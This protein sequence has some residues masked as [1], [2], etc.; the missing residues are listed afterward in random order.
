M[1]YSRNVSI[2]ALQELVKNFQL[3]PPSPRYGYSFASWAGGRILLPPCGVRSAEYPSGVCSAE[4]PAGRGLVTAL[5][6]EL[7]VAFVS[8]VQRVPG[9]CPVQLC[10]LLQRSIHDS[11]AHTAARGWLQRARPSADS[12]SPSR[13][14]YAF[15][16]RE[17]CT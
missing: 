7:S 8:A 17:D 11:L 14:F 2:F 9:L 4:Y 15:G 5:C 16:L 13:I 3:P 1:T 6:T 12:Q 10:K